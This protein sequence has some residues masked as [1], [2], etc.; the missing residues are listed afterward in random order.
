MNSAQW[1]MRTKIT[2]G[3]GQ[4]AVKVWEEFKEGAG[5]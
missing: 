3:Q 2:R 1:V 4:D 5:K